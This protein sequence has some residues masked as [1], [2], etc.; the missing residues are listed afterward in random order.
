MKDPTPRRTDCMKAFDKSLNI[1]KECPPKRL[2]YQRAS[3]K[4]NS[5]PCCQ[6]REGNLEVENLARKKAY[7]IIFF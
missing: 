2:S 4:W 1:L 5:E 3:Q 6:S 7:S